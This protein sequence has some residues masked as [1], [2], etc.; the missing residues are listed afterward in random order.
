MQWPLKGTGKMPSPPCLIRM[1]I[2]CLI[3]KEKLQS[4]GIFTKIGWE[5]RIYPLWF[6]IF[7]ICLTIMVIFSFFVIR[8]LLKKLIAWLRI[9]QEIKP[10][11]QMG[12]MDVS[13]NPAGQLLLK[14]FIG[15][16]RADFWGGSIDL[17]AINYII[18]TWSHL[19]YAHNVLEYMLQVATNL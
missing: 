9:C 1:A 7:R 3:M 11:A 19:S 15:C 14:I 5:F 13:S 17:S 10:Q 6:L 18:N 16:M 2:R 4:S 8:S 12:S